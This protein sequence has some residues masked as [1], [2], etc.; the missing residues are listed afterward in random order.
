MTKSRFNMNNSARIF[1]ASLAILL[2]LSP[3]P[4]A[5]ETYTG[6]VVRVLD[7]DT[8]EV[9]DASNTPHRVRLAGIDA[10]EKAQPFGAKSK[11]NLLS[12]VG[13]RQVAVDWTKTDRYGRQVG[14]I[15]VE[16]DILADLKDG[17]SY[18]ATRKQARE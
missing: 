8:A 16:V 7:G 17:D 15:L 13:G 3:I 18:G 4:A 10:P 1:S 9:L 14:K 5:A 2:F 6:T 12:L 11:Q